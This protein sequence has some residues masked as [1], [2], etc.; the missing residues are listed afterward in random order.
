MHSV[1]EMHSNRVAHLLKT[2]RHVGKNLRMQYNVV[3]FLHDD[4][5]RPKRIH[6][7]EEARNAVAEIVGTS[8]HSLLG[9]RLTRRTA[10]Q[11]CRS[12]GESP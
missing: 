7:I 10:H 3:D 5:Q 9:V 8:L 6:G 4:H 2:K 11:D 12:I 1:A